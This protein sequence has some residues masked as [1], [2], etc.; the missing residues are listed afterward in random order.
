[1]GVSLVVERYLICD[2]LDCDNNTIDVGRDFPNAFILRQRMKTN[3]WH[4][5]LSLDF[6]PECW[7]KR[8][9]G[10]GK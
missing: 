8:A 7:A 5:E 9:G 1:M 3:G 2:Y 6:C 10:R 4:N